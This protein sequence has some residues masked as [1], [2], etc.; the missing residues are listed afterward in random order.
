[1]NHNPKKDCLLFQGTPKS[2][3]EKFS[4][5]ICLGETVEN[6]RSHDKL[7]DY[8][9]TAHSSCLNLRTMWGKGQ[10]SRSINSIKKVMSS[11]DVLWMSFGM[12]VISQQLLCILQNITW[13]QHHPSTRMLVQIKHQTTRFTLFQTII[14]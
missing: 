6:L 13:T 2:K 1:M 11:M 14:D 9:L 4:I 12:N 10:T 7:Y 5:P 8:L 3:K